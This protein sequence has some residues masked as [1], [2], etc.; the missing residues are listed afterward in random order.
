M[1]APIRIVIIAPT[2]ALRAGLRALLDAPDLEVVDEAAAPSQ[3][4]LDTAQVDVVLLGE[5][6]L[7]SELRYM[8]S[9]DAQLAILLL[10]DD[11]QPAFELHNMALRGW[12]LL[13][14]ESEPDERCV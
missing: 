2:P 7:L 6:G 14:N 5:A 13:P 11:Q 9:D 1:Y 8:L 4:L 10:S 3:A 12:S